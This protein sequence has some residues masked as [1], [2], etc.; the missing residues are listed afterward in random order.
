MV[1]IETLVHQKKGLVLNLVNQT[2]NVARV[3]IIMLIIVAFLLLENKYFNLRLTIKMLNFQQKFVWEVF[4][5]DLMLVS[6]EKYGSGN[7]YDFTV[8]FNSYD[9]SDMLK[10]YKY[11][12]NKNN[13]K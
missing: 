6:L 1:L 4:L 8:S 12:M 2:Q 11:L 7:V 13:M 3:Y 9:K 5:M 10:I